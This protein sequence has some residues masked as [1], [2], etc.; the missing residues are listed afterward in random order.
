MITGQ[1]SKNQVMHLLH[2][3]MPYVKHNHQVFF[4]YD[5]VSSRTLHDALRLMLATCLGLYS[6]SSRN[7]CG[8]FA[9]SLTPCS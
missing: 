3:S 7:Q 5:T 4:S 6:E 1:K 2:M 9:F 8:T